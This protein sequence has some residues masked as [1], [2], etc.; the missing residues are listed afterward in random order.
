MQEIDG[1]NKEMENEC[2]ESTLHFILSNHK[3]YKLLDKMI[4]SCSITQVEEIPEQYNGNCV[5]ELPPASSKGKPMEGM[6]QK[7]D[8]HVWVKPLSTQMSFPATIRRSKCAGHLICSNEYCPIKGIFGQPNEIAWIGK[9]STPIVTE[10][11][12]SLASETLACFHC[13]NVAVLLRECQYVAYYIFS[14]ENKS[15]LFIH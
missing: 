13:G 5:Y 1:K 6:E 4:V 2:F 15:R 8:G 10:G 14:G 11:M 9:L 12:F 3:K 7:Y